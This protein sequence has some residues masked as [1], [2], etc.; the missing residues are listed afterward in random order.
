MS[1]SAASPR[2]S[3][4]TYNVYP[5]NTYQSRNDKPTLKGYITESAAQSELYGL[6]VK[7]LREEIVEITGWYWQAGWPPYVGA[8]TNGYVDVRTGKKYPEGT[9]FLDDVVSS[10]RSF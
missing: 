10:P 9:P 7:F 3:Y 5:W 6:H 4:N 1:S 2:P 8:E